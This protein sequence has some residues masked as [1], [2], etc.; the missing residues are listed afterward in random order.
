MTLLNLNSG[1]RTVSLVLVLGFASGAS[2]QV[3]FYTSKPSFDAVATANL[4]ETFESAPTK[5]S[6]L[7]TLTLNGVTYQGFAGTPSPNV[8]VVS[9]GANNFGAGVGTTTSSILSANGDEDF[10]ATFS[11]SYTAIGFDSYLNGLGAATVKVFNGSTL[12][13]T[14]TYASSVDTKEYLGI[15]STSPITS[16]RWTSTLGASLN[17]GIDNISVGAVP[18]PAVAASVVA[19]LALIGA[20]VVR[21]WRAQK[22]AALGGGGVLVGTQDAGAAGGCRSP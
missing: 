21:H 10:T 17:T 16:I 4:L 15:V 6:A 12:L 19:V 2:G 22:E 1:P 5:D 11:T 13:A 14:Y 9:A 7:S 20:C 8:Y 3:T 18:E